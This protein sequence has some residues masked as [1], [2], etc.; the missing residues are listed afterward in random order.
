MFEVFVI[1]TRPAVEKV[2][3][4]EWFADKSEADI[5]CEEINKGYS[6]VDEGPFHVYPVYLTFPTEG[7]RGPFKEP[8]TFPEII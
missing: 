4:S 5:I 1:A 6:D 2:W 8:W 3:G 7:Q